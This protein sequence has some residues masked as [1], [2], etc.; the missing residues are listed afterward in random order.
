MSYFRFIL[1]FRICFTH[2]D[3]PLY[4]QLKSKK[5]YP[6]SKMAWKVQFFIDSC[7][8]LTWQ[9][10]HWMYHHFAKKRKKKKKKWDLE[11]MVTLRRSHSQCHHTS[12]LTFRLTSLE[13]VAESKWLQLPIQWMMWL[14]LHVICFYKNQDSSQSPW[15]LGKWH[16]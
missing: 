3:N 16:I 9:N 11:I 14:W 2:S 8:Q 5:F 4:V 15:L 10:D 13:N 7:P 6:I 1:K 12:L